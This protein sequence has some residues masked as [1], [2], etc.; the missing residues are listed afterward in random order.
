MEF[1][2]RWELLFTPVDDAWAEELEYVT[3]PLTLWGDAGCREGLFLRTF[4]VRVIIGERR[5]GRRDAFGAERGAQNDP[6]ED[7]AAHPGNRRDGVRPPD[8][9]QEDVGHGPGC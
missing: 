6:V 4:A 8:D 5:H 2:M 3:I 9:E 7:A 1:S